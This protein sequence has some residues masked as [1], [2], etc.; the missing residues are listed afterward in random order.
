[1]LVLSRKI[2]ESIEADGP[3]KFS[4]LEVIG[5]KVR[6]GIEADRSVNITRPDAKKLRQPKNNG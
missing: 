3:A 2:G 6:I 1:M 5:N 4:V